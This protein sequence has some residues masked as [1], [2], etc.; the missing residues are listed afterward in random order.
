M[1][2]ENLKQMS[3][4]VLKLFPKQHTKQENEFSSLT[5][6]KN[7]TGQQTFLTSICKLLFKKN[8]FKN[9]SFRNVIAKIVHIHISEQ[10]IQERFKLICTNE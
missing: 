9:S 8:Y 1:S 7:G 4:F 10:F 6:K 5:L 3:F 2:I